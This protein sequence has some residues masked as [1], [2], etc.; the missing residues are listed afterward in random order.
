MSDPMYC[1]LL[2]P[3]KVPASS[4]ILTYHG[5]TYYSSSKRCKLAVQNDPT[6]S[7]GRCRR[8]DSD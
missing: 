3:A 1:M 6:V 7:A 4:N 8:N 2:N 5:A